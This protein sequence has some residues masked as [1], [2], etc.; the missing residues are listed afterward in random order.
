MKTNNRNPVQARPAQPAAR[1]P[2]Q[3][4]HD[5][6][7]GLGLA[8]QRNGSATQRLLASMNN[9]PQIAAQRLQIESAF[10]E[11]VQRQIPEGEGEEPLQGMFDLQASASVQAQPAPPPNNT[12][13]PDN[14]KSGIE[15]LSGINMGDVRVQRNSSK[16]A[17]LNALAY[18]QGAQIH[19]GPGQ[20]RHLPHEA[21][22]AVQQKQGRV[23]PT[24]NISGMPLNDSKVLEGEADRMG[25]KALQMNSMA[26]PKKPAQFKKS[27]ADAIIQ[28][29]RYRSI[30][31]AGLTVNVDARNDGVRAQATKTDEDYEESSLEYALNSYMDASAEGGTKA[32]GV[33][34]ATQTNTMHAYP[35]RAGIG[36]LMVSEAMDFMNA[37]G[38]AYF[39]PDIMISEGGRI[40]KALISG[41]NRNA[42][43]M[44]QLIAQTDQ[45][46]AAE[47][48]CCSCWDFFTSLF[49]CG[50]P[51]TGEGTSLL[52]AEAQAP[53]VRT[54]AAIEVDFATTQR[55]LQARVR[56]KFARI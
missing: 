3:V 23:K 33:A 53:R 30:A 25:A 9:S 36:T 44:E 31:N 13:L 17:Q 15:S 2:S 41:T 46:E 16:P 40:M 21:W 29:A 45:R 19:L 18:T 6:P 8:D 47:T 49:S 28:M 22:H 14:L 11:A 52:D 20:E 37:R 56:R 27:G 38:M 50:S 51:Q 24:G 4:R 26:D 1:Q 35:Q 43:Y 55:N 10:G 34:M 39:Q 54:Y 48:S 7:D 5:H 32:T 12:G 42:A